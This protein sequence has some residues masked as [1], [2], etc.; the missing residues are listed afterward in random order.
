MSTYALTDSMTMLRRNLK[1]AQRYP[2][3]PI[4]T[5]ATPVLMLL[6]FAGVFGSAL[7]A[8]IG[9]SP[10]GYIDYLTPGVLLMAATSGSI[11]IAISVSM[12]ATQG[13]MNRFRTMA[14]ARSSILTGQVIGGVLQTMTS[15]VAVVGVAL[16][17]GF[18]P[19][20]TPVEWVLAAGILILL[21][22]ALSWLAAAIGLVAKGPEQASNW[23]MPVTFLPLLG[24]GFV[25]TDSMP[26]GV[27][28]F[29]EYQPFTP[30]IETLRGLLM[31]T[32]IGNS[33]WLAIGW[34]VVI[35]V[36][37]FWWAR[38]AFARAANRVG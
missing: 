24:S 32:G 18:R 16:L 7:G 29:A 11:A 23:P 37:G 5:I 35:T 15:I 30:I 33:G 1:H 19:D 12:D 14:I 8:G 4:S 38:A 27:R 26:A 20:A 2:S 21:T 25:P 13:V 10:G 17:M 36:G 3:L 31:G 28:Q 34:C 6:L 9:G 22:F